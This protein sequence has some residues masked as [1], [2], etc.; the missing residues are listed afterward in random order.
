MLDLSTGKR[1]DCFGV[2]KANAPFRELLAA[3]DES[4]PSLPFRWVYV[5]V[6]NY[7]IHQVTAVKQWWVHYSRL[8]LLVLPT[9]DPEPTRSSAYSVMLHGLCARHH[10]RKRLRDWVADVEA[11]VQANGPWLYKVSDIYYEPAVTAAVEGMM[12]EEPLSSAA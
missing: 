6:D 1:L 7:K 12:P 4:Y 3:R 5:T 2:R 11:Y 10:Q 8:T 9:Y